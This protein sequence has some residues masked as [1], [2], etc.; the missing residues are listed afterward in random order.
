MTRKTDES[1]SSHF[2]AA[3]A[4]ARAIQEEPRWAEWSE[5]TDAADADPELTGLADRYRE[6]AVL[7]HAGRGDKAELDKV[8][9]RIRRHPAYR[10]QESA[11]AAMVDLLREVNVTLSEQLGLDFAS[12]AVP[13]KSGGCC[14]C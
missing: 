1:E 8:A 7:V 2:E 5:A 14:G 13:R 6:L 10:R 4:L 9:D 12:A 11:E 3:A